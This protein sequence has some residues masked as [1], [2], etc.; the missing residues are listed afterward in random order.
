MMIDLNKEEL[1]KGIRA[2][3]RNA[4]GGNILSQSELYECY[5]TGKDIG[6]INLDRAGFYFEQ[7]HSSM[8]QA[9]FCIHKLNLYE[10]R[11][12]RAL[13]IEFEPDLTVVI[14]ENG[15]G[16]TSVVDAI[17]R[18]LSWFSNR[19]VKANSNGLP[20]L[21]F[22]INTH[23]KDYAQIVGSFSLN[24]TTA[25]DMSLVK[26]VSG[27][28]GEISSSLQVSTQLGAIYRLLVANEE[29][30]KTQ[31]PVFA[32]YA[33][34]RTFTGSFRGGRDTEL[35]T[36]F[37]SRFNAYKDFS[38]AS[39]RTDSFLMRYV[40]LCNLAGSSD[41]YKA[42]IQLVDQAIESAVPYIRKLELDRSSGRD[43]V[44]L[45]NFGNRINFLQLS[46]GQKTLAALVGD[47][48]LRMLTLNPAM[49]NPLEA[50][51]VVLIDEIELHLHPQ[52][53]Q[54]ILIRL[55]E[56]FKNV[57]FIVTTH[58]PHV[59]STVDKKSIRILGSEDHGTAYVEKPSFQTKGVMSSDVLEQLMGT[60]SV[61]NIKESKWITNYQALIEQNIWENDEG[62]CL[63][64]KLRDHFGNDHPVIKELDAQI[65]LQQLKKRIRQKG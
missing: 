49:T 39:A 62:L 52:W 63:K 3:I 28:A 40:E 55:V 1:P 34:E 30:D 50:H 38:G 59:L 26:A 61:P 53:Q 42:K 35:K 31:L 15:A 18:L 24:E 16:K 10:F 64:R 32:Y 44:K 27:W 33:V 48:A 41:Y 65:S 19:I 2:L 37:A 22:D 51:G 17:A 25:F 13:H 47:L 4:K 14:G 46:H 20:V 21:D 11:R 5:L 58:S 12:Y 8:E 45:D 7:L 9:R 36:F 57:Q 56:T 6:A 29:R 54:H 60:H 23:A 43:E